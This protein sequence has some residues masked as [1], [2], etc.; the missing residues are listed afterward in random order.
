[1]ANVITRPSL[2][3]MAGAVLTAL[4][5]AA[6]G[7]AAAG[8]VV[9]VAV[10]D[11][12]HEEQRVPVAELLCVCAASAGAWWN[13]PRLWVWER[14]GGVRTRLRAAAVAAVGVALPVL[15]ILAVLPTALTVDH[16]WLMVT[17]VLFAASA[18]YLLTPF[19]GPVVAGAAVL[20]GVFAGAAACNLAPGLNRVVPYAY[21]DGDGWVAPELLPPGTVFGLA[22][23]AA[24]A[25]VA[26]H[27]ATRGATTR[28]HLRAEAER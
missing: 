19:L 15:A 9:P 28:V 6:L 11:W 20:A 25:A 5:A 13:R 3:P 27:A 4:A 18:V 10:A 26:V 16:R 8:T 17:N 1:M 24:L 14:L 7:L 23:T 2:L 22:V 21:A 12:P